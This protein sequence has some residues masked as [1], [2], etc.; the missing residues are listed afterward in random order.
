VTATPPRP[1]DADTRTVD[2]ARGRGPGPLRRVLDGVGRVLLGIRNAWAGA[3]SGQRPLLVVLAVALVLGIV[4]LSGPFERY[5]DS[6]TRVEAL[7][8]TAETLDEENARLDRRADL[9]EDP[10]ELERLAREEQGM[11]RPG[12]VPYTLVPPEV[13]RPVISSPRNLD[14]D[15]A[16]PPWYVRAW[17]AVRSWF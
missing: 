16:A 11:I 1:P 4:M 12:E 6:R 7:R 8:A 15:D 2:R 17:D 9:L 14:D 3:R 10:A 13:D 5:A